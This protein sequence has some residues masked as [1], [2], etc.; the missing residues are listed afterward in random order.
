MEFAHSLL[1]L[2]MLLDRL[3]TSRS[4]RRFW[5]PKPR[6]VWA[7]FRGVKQSQEVL[8]EGENDENEGKWTFLFAKRTESS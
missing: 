7:H 8:D 5:Y 1:V 3:D 4:R 2:M 6:S